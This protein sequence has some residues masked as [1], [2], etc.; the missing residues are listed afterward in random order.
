MYIYIQYIWVHPYI[1]M[2]LHT[3]HVC[4]Y[5]VWG[6]THILY[7]YAHNYTIATVLWPHT[8]DVCVYD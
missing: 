8:F 7:A 2:K 5:T 3:V 1:Y 4:I 6:T